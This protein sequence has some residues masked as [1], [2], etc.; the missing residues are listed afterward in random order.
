MKTQVGFNYLCNPMLGLAREMI[1]SGELGK[2]RGA[3]NSIT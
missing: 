2:I 1:A 3:N